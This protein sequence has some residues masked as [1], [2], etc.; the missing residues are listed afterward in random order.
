MSK[1]RTGWIL[2]LFVVLLALMVRFVRLDAVPA[3]LYY[4]EIDLGYQIRSLLSTGKD[5]RGGL[6]PFYLRSF[7]TD[8]TP[9]PIYFSV[10]PSLFFS[11][12]EY[13]VRAG[14]ALAGVICVILAMILVY[15]LTGKKNASIITGLV[16]A[17]SPWQIQFSRMAFEAIFM[18]V[19]FLA[20]VSVF[21]YWKDSKK[22]WAFYL[23]AVLFGLN[24]YTY[25]T[26]SL[27]GP[28]LVGLVTV[29]YFRDFW[30]QGWWRL[31][32]W[33]SII[34][35]FVLPFIYA[36][37]IGSADQARINQISVFSDPMTQVKVLRNREVDS[38]DYGNPQ[39]GKKAVWWSPIFHNKVLTPLVN[40]GSNY[41][42]NYSTEFLFLTG[43]PNGR[44]SVTNMGELLFIDSLG[45]I[46]GLTFVFKNIKDKKYQ[47]LL[48]LLIFS[49]VASD[50]TMDGAYH[51]SRLMILA[52]P[53]LLIVGLGYFSLLE[54]LFK[55]KKL[56][57]GIPLI[58]GLWLLSTIFY[59]HRY[60]VHF[61]IE[62]SRQFGYGYKQ[63]MIKIADVE[64]QFK[65]IRLTNL[66]DP[67]MLYYFFW[68]N[69]APINVQEYGTAYGEDVY[70][71]MPLDKIKQI[72]WGGKTVHS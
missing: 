62:S 20:S 8:K 38:N 24:V 60:F 36:T 44:H 47:L 4:D 57:L 54:I 31:G 43:D 35:I 34:A 16:F 46:V 41:L 15:Q 22:N 7:N 2:I 59:L 40:F 26:M 21:L 12:P 23:S 5:Y 52:G 48:C 68:R 37:T 28:I 67:P 49:P 39:I 11:S 14:A 6:S 9:F 32:V 65:A 50:L 56:W 61:P 33:L 25:R 70:R 66:N 69:E 30:R 17:F 13:Q 19:V 53:M 42:K 10:L 1:K 45:L 64:D 55:N 72:S 63:A 18:L 51:A 58:T 3:S 71:N 29:I 27:F